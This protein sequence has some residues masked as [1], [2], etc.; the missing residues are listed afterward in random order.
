FDITTD[1]DSGQTINMNSGVQ[2]EPQNVKLFIT[3][4]IAIAF[5]SSGKEG[6]L[7]S[8]A[9]NRIIRVQLD[10][11]GTPTINPQKF[12]GDTDVIVKD[13]VVLNPQGIVLN[14]KSTRAYVENFI[15]RDISVVDI[16]AANP[17]QI[18]R[19]PSAPLPAAG[20]LEA[21]VLRGHELFNTG[22]GPAG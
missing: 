3:N 16:S 4:P 13:K 2:N 19:I 11:D 9:T 18:T 14:S 12:V 22:I 15:S 7:V 10:G 6:W 1:T 20:T 5:E 17:F 21:I 8:A